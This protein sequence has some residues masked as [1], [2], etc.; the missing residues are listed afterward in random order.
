MT[1]KIVP[2]AR[3]GHQHGPGRGR[4]LLVSSPRYASPNTRRGYTGVGWTWLLTPPGSAPAGRWREVSGEELAG[5]L[6][7]LGGSGP[8]DLEPQPRRRGRLAVLVRRQ[9]LP[10]PVLP[11]AKPNGR[12]EHINAT[13]RG[14][15]A[16]ESTTGPLSRPRR[17]RCGRRPCGGCCTRPPPAP[18]KSWR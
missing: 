9:P 10:A 1:G 3:T 16:G 13:A 17:G 8:G 12:R 2:I 15:P 5:L 18:A 4:R 11:A 7:Q 14:A 6:E